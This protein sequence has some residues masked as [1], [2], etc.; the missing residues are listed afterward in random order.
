MMQKIT[1]ITKNEITKGD[2]KMKERKAYQILQQLVINAPDICIADKTD[3]LRLLF[4]Q[5]D[6]SVLKGE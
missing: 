5:E 4:E 6:L 1:K 3:L 2:K